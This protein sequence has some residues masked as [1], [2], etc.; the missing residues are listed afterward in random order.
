MVKGVAV[1][2]EG[3]RWG[4]VKGVAVVREGGREVG[5]WLKV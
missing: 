1:V 4:M 2:R 5:G 3:G